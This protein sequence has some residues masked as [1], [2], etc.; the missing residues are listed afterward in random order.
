[1]V[2]EAPWFDG[3]D[4]TLVLSGGYD[5]DG[6]A[7]PTTHIYDVEERSW[8]EGARSSASDDHTP[9]AR[10]FHTATYVCVDNEPYLFVVGGLHM[11]SNT[12]NTRDSE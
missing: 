5:D 9:S 2:S 8:V 12:H 10:S 1:M 4:V 3:A 7:P 6:H 11:R